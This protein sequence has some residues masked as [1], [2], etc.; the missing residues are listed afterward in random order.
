M[1]D[2]IVI[3][4]S[5][6]L[7]SAKPEV[8]YCGQSGSEAEKAVAETNG[9]YALVYRLKHTEQGQKYKSHQMVAAAVAEP[10]VE[11]IQSPKKSKSK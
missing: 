4:K 5:S 2:V 11:V 7:A 3:G 9:K 10:V 8:I 1:S 6:F